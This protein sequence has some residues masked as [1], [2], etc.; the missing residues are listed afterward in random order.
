MSSVKKLFYF[1]YNFIK[2]YNLLKMKK[3]QV[4]LCEKLREQPAQTL[5][6]YDR[7]FDN[8]KLLSSSYLQEI[9]S[10]QIYSNTNLH[11]LQ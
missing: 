9:C 11:I 5:S 6:D 3:Y 10:T 4:F 8:V 1:D 7:M 2:N